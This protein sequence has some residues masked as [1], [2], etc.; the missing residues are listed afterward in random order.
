MPASASYLTKYLNAGTRS[1]N[2]TNTTASGD[3]EESSRPKKRRKKDKSTLANA[4]G[5]L[6]I[7]DD[8]EE[9]LLSSNSK[10]RNEEDDEDPLLYTGNVRSVEFRKKKSSSWKAVGDATAG[11]SAGATDGGEPQGSTQENGDGDKDEDEATKILNAAAAESAQR[12]AIINDEDAP[13]IVGDVTTTTQDA[14]QPSR[15]L[16]SSGAPAGLQ[17]AAD[18]AALLAAQKESDSQPPTDRKKKRRP[19]DEE[20]EPEPETIYRD[21]S[22]RRIDVSLLRSEARAQAAQKVQAEKQARDSAMGE[23]QLR[24]RED[25]KQ[26]LEEA[27]FLTVGR[28]V[29]DEEMNERMRGAVRWDDPMAGYIARKKGEE[30]E[31]SGKG[32]DE[33]VSVRRKAKSGRREYAGAAPPNRYGIKPGWRWDGVDRGNGF[34]KEWFQARG[35]KTRN[36]NLEYQWAYDE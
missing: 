19:K 10:S 22:G 20:R 1:T 30:A 17:T 4:T 5:T 24:E 3:F 33:D 31:I 25:A 27:K 23:V 8:D 7:A 13:T 29:D 26:E 2:G 16:M 36:E 34:E 32:D 15:V 18:T 35:K 14:P 9:L 6:L 12:T 28:D 21:A 11:E